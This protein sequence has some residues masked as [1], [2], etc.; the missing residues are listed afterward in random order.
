MSPTPPVMRVRNRRF[1]SGDQGRAPI[2]RLNP[3]TQR[4]ALHAS[5]G[6]ALIGELARTGVHGSNVPFAVEYQPTGSALPDIESSSLIR[7]SL[8][9]TMAS[10]DFPRHFLLGISPDKDVN[11]HCATARFTLSTESQDFVVMCQLV[12]WTRPSIAFLFVGSQLCLLA[13][14]G[15]SVTLPSLPQTSSYRYDSPTGD[16]NPISSRP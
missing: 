16:F 9:G 11:L 10:A 6:M 5:H 15:R 4:Q 13:S 1:R 3:K 8:L 7:G 12:P 14:S 2:T